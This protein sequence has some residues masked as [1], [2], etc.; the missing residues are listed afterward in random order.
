[1][2]STPPRHT[3]ARLLL[4]LLLL[5]PLTPNGVSSPILSSKVFWRVEAA[6]VR[7]AAPGRRPIAGRPPRSGGGASG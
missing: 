4:L 5:Q 7:S 1:M 3:R 2:P 6:G